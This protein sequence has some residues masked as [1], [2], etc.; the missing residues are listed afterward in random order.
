MNI[1]EYMLICWKPLLGVLGSLSVVELL[2]CWVSWP[3][4]PLENFSAMQLQLVSFDFWQHCSSLKIVKHP[5]KA[6]GKRLNTWV[7]D[8]R[9]FTSRSFFF[10][11]QWLQS[12]NATEIKLA[13]D[14]NSAA[15]LVSGDNQISCNPSGI[16]PWAIQIHRWL[17]YL[18]VEIDRGFYQRWYSSNVQDLF[19]HAPWQLACQRYPKCSGRGIVPPEGTFRNSVHR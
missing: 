15:P 2:L 3:V 17:Q 6:P 18:V 5:C 8:D 10:A 7:K 12:S 16:L 14:W 4:P 19:K 9:I 11:P 13:C 1:I